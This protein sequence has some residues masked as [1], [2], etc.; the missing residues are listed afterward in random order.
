MSSPPCEL[1]WE[2]LLPYVFDPSLLEMT[3]LRIPSP[4]PDSPDYTC[5]GSEESSFS[6]DESCPPCEL[7]EGDALH[8]SGRGVIPYALEEG[9]TSCGSKGAPLPYP[10]ATRL[11]G[12]SPRKLRIKLKPRSLGEPSQSRPETTTLCVVDA[13]STPGPLPGGE[14]IVPLEPS[15]D[16]SPLKSSMRP[17]GCQALLRFFFQKNF[18]FYAPEPSECPNVMRSGGRI[19]FMKKVL[20]KALSQAENF[21]VQVLDR[22]LEEGRVWDVNM[23]PSLSSLQLAGIISGSPDLRFPELKLSSSSFLSVGGGGFIRSHGP[24]DD[25]VE[26]YIG[27]KE[28]ELRTPPLQD[29]TGI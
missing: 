29:L 9:V 1:S 19:G 26:S 28:T 21:L 22:R 4:A 5:Q 11:E 16:E 13:V 18:K 12:R 27:S 20:K 3:P 17:A 8:V 24:G 25:D 2:P 6:S 23:K 10:S 15:N 7:G 14:D